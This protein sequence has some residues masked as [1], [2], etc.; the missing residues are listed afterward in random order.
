MHDQLIGMDIYAL[1]KM[2]PEF[3]TLFKDNFTNNIH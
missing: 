3:T 1:Q 2:L